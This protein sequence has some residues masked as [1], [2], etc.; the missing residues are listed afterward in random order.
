MERSFALTTPPDTAA[1]FPSDSQGHSVQPTSHRIAPGYRPRLS[2]EHQKC[3]LEGILGV[4]F[5]DQD[6]PAH[7]KHQRSMALHERREGFF[8]AM[9]DELPQQVRIAP[10][11]HLRGDNE[12]ANIPQHRACWTVC[13]G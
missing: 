8:V 13:H 3:G 4:L 5:L 10:A 12:P 1:N 7:A 11:A 2:R 9:L 6:A